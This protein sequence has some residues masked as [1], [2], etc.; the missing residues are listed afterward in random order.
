MIALDTDIEFYHLEII[1][2]H[3]CDFYDLIVFY[4]IGKNASKKS[5]LIADF[6]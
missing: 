2:V 4:S 1:S 6:T 5:T 3:F